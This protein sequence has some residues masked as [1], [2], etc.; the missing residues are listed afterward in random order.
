YQDLQIHGRG[1]GLANALIYLLAAQAPAVV[2]NLGNENLHEFTVAAQGRLGIGMVGQNGQC[3]LAGTAAFISSF[4]AAGM[5]IAMVQTGIK[6]LSVYFNRHRLAD[7]L[8][9]I[10]FQ[11]PII[12][13]N[14][15]S[16]TSIWPSM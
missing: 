11:L 12:V 13:Q 9:F 15:Q 7:S 16:G 1:G 3:K 6:G 2:F 4:I 5:D 14:V 10:I 8:A